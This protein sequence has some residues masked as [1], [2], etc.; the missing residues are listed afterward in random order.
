MSFDDNELPTVKE[1]K[2]ELDSLR[3]RNARLEALFTETAEKYA[4]LAGRT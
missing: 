2:R 1:M 3:E 4:K